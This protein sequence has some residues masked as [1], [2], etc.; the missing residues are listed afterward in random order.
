MPWPSPTAANVPKLLGAAKLAA[1]LRQKKLDDG[2]E[3]AEEI[4]QLEH[5]AEYH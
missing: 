5:F 4:G 3:I 2:F 1:E